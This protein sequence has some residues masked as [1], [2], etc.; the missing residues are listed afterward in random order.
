MPVCNRAWR[1]VTCEDGD[2]AHG[3]EMFSLGEGGAS[4]PGF[5]LALRGYARGQVDRY[6]AQLEAEIAALTAERE[7]A[8]AQIQA[9]A[10]QV[11]HLQQEM[12]QLRHQTAADASVS[13]RHLGPR[14]EQILTLAE[15]QAEAIRASAVQEIAG[16]RAE[17]D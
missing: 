11:H 7:E 5:D 2:M 9:L 10:T 3:G 14:V 4:E 13:F 12:T 8:Y 6:V 1:D 17:L 15:E 16:Q